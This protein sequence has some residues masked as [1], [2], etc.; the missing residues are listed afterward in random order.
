MEHYLVAIATIIFGIIGIVSFLAIT[1]RDYFDDSWRR[2]IVLILSMSGFL[3]FGT[4]FI[5]SFFKN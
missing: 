1:E 2:Y 5:Y 4:Y 3:I